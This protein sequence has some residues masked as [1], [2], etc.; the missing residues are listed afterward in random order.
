MRYGVLGTGSVGQASGRD[1][2]PVWTISRWNRCRHN[3]ERRVT[4]RTP[5]TAHQAAVYIESRL[6]V[7]SQAGAPVS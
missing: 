3:E 6:I 7:A 1:D 2:A 5:S 4:A